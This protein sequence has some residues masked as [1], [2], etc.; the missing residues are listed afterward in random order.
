MLLVPLMCRHKLPTT[1]G[2]G[3]QVTEANCGNLA[4]ADATEGTMTYSNSTKTLTLDNVKID[5]SGSIN[6]I[7]IIRST[8]M[9][10]K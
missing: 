8:L 1:Y 5:K 7:N 4:P 10:L 9:D 6:S 3:T 2:L